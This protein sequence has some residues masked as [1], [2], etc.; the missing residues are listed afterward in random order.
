MSQVQRFYDTNAEKE[1][2]RL[3]FECEPYRWLEFRVATHIM[4]KHLPPPPARVL[5]VGAGPGR[6]T[7]ALAEK[8]YCVTLFDLSGASLALARRNVGEA[9]V[10][11]RVAGYKQGSATDLG[12]FESGSCDA[13]LNMGPLYHLV[14]EEDPAFTEAYFAHPWELR[15]W[16][17]DE[18]A[19]TVTMAAQ[20]GVAGGQRDGCRRLAENLVAWQHF[21]QI[22]LETCEDPT[23]LGG[24]EHTLHL[25][26]KQV[27]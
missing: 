14:I 10:A 21:V 25:G 26:R 19:E 9:G 1:W 12:C 18:G 20:E 7:I 15:R 8:G 4:E 11:H 17:E 16:F 3:A 23:I 6:Y 2:E 5:D 27:S 13:V 24:S 22:A